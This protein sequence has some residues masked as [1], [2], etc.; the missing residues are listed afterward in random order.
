ML[1][2]KRAGGPAGACWRRK[3]LITVLYTKNVERIEEPRPRPQVDTYS[4]FFACSAA[5]LSMSKNL[6]FLDAAVAKR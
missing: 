5:S 1:S 4:C 3:N 2:L 6:F